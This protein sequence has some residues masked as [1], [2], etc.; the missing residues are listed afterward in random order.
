MS[1]PREQ[2]VEVQQMDAPSLGFEE[3]IA[4]GDQTGSADTMHEAVRR[5]QGH[6]L[7]IG[8]VVREVPDPGVAR[9]L[10]GT[11]ER[12]EDPRATGASAG[13]A[14]GCELALERP[15]IQAAMSPADRRPAMEAP[16]PGAARDEPPQLARGAR[17]AR[18]I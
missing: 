1:E 2:R 7:R 17:P 16:S 4:D 18:L 3:Q 9:N 5:D 15:E 6:L 10:A 11:V 13:R 12:E 8:V 14:E